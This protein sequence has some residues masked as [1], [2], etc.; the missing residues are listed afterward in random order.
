MRSLIQNNDQLRTRMTFALSQILVVGGDSFSDSHPAQSIDYVDILT[1]NAF[2][3]YRQLL[4]DVTF[5]SIMASW[6]TYRNNRKGDPA[7]GRV[8]DENYAREL[9]Q[10]FSLG[11]L[12][13]NNDVSL[14]LD[15]SGNPIEL[16]GNEDI[17]NLARVFTGYAAQGRRFGIRSTDP[18]SLEEI[19]LQIFADQH[20]ALEKNFLNINIPANTTG[21]DS[22]KLALDG[23][24]SHPNIA[25][26]ISRQLI[27][28]FTAS[29][30]IP[31]LCR[32]CC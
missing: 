14:I 23:I 6:L 24:F 28:R 16:Y 15:E 2:G 17:V 27:Q 18:R 20:S 4:E 7:T 13:L 29:R 11:L 12:E 5:S 19:P 21:E 10:L 25:P 9:L 31:G 22:L 1:R 30:P 32:A 3:N 8:P 26:F